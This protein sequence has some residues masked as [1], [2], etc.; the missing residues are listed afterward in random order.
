MKILVTGGAGYIGSHMLKLLREENEE[1]VVF[2]DEDRRLSNV[3][4]R[5]DECSGHAP[6]PAL[7]LSAC[8]R[9]SFHA[10]VPGNIVKFGD[11]RIITL[12]DD[13]R[14]RARSRREVVDGERCRRVL[15]SVA[16]P[17]LGDLLARQFDREDLEDEDFGSLLGTDA[18]SRLL[19]GNWALLGLGITMFAFNTVPVD[20]FVHEAARL[21]E[22][23]VP[24]VL[25]CGERWEITR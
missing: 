23:V 20:T 9:P 14:A 24:R 25:Q 18:G 6:P 7:P 3:L 17:L 13:T 21:P 12:C 1:H 22:G 4:G 15:I 10:V 2:D 11:C 16:P 19:H 5:L 8:S